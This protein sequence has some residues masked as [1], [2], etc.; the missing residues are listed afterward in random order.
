MDIDSRTE[1]KGIFRRSPR[2]LSML[3]P[4]QLFLFRITGVDLFNI[5]RFLSPVLM[6]KHVTLF[7]S[8]ETREDL[9]GMNI[10]V[11]IDNCVFCHSDI[12]LGKQLFIIV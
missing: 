12:K 2:V 4:V 11:V 5:Q 10:K 3:G 6:T 9:L 8:I 7:F 1:L